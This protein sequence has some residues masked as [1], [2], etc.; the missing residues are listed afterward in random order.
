MVDLKYPGCFFI[1][2]NDYSKKIA[3]YLEALKDQNNNHDSFLVNLLRIIAI[4]VDFK[5]SGRIYC[6]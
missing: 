3:A 2:T 4:T 1:M 5:V 6:C